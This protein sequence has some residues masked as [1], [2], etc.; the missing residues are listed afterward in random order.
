[1]KH[2][3]FVGFLSFLSFFFFLSPS[4]FVRMSPHLVICECKSLAHPHQN[5]VRFALALASPFFFFFL[6]PVVTVCRS[7]LCVCACRVQRVSGRSP[8]P[9]QGISVGL[10]EFQR[11]RADPSRGRISGHGAETVAKGG[12]ERERSRR[13]KAEGV[14]DRPTDPPLRGYVQRITSAL[15]GATWSSRSKLHPRT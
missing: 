9:T 10:W 11:P 7:D 13:P 12:G 14:I 1:M 6:P 5:K 4:I 8:G 15:V 2:P 3:S